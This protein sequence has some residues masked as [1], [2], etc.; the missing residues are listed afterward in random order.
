MSQIE[1]LVVVD[2]PYLL[3]FAGVLLVFTLL[4]ML[5][6]FKTS[7]SVFMIFLPGFFALV[8]LGTHNLAG[9]YLR[10]D[11]LNKAFANGERPCL[12]YK[13]E[14]RTVDFCKYELIDSKAKSI[15]S[16]ELFPLAKCVA[17]VGIKTESEE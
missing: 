8:I 11:I 12:R 6:F 7:T 4:R 13:H 5:T 10:T 2:S 1:L 3:V 9:D 16:G 14:E 15:S 17:L